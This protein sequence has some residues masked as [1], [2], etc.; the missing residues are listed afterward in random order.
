LLVSETV[1]GTIGSSARFCNAV[2]IMI[3]GVAWFERVNVT[4][5][6]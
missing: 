2:I 6:R 5:G 4:N 1:D 3:L